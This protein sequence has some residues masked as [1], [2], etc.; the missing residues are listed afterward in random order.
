MIPYTHADMTRHAKRARDEHVRLVRNP[1]DGSYHAT[2]AQTGE[3][4]YDLTGSLVDDDPDLVALISCSCPSTG[5]CKH[6][7]AFAHFLDTQRAHD[8]AVFLARRGARKRRAGA[9]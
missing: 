6:G 2:S 3:V 1:K 7:G 4:A 8:A 9:A 5:P